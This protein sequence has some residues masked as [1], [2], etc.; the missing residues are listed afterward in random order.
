MDTAPPLVTIHTTASDI[1]RMIPLSPA[2]AALRPMRPLPKCSVSDG[3]G[4]IEPVTCL[5][6]AA[7]PE[8][9]EQS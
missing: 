4:V 8:A 2:Q 1:C 6:M 7:D 3:Q 9:L 5:Q